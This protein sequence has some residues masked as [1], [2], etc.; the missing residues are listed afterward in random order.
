MPFGGYWGKILRVNLTTKKISVQEFDE[1]FARKWLGGVGFAVKICYDE[2]PA[3]ADPLGPENLLVYACGPY[4]GYTAIQGSGRFAVCGK[5]PLTGIWGQSTGGGHSAEELKRAGFDAVVV[6]GASDKPVYIYVNDGEIEIKD[7]NHLWGKDAGET[8]D[9]LKQELGDKVRVVPIGPAGENL[10]RYAGVITEKGHGC[11]GRMGMG[12]IMGSKKLKALVFRGTM[13]QPI[14]NP[15]ELKKLNKEL[16]PVLQNNDF[17]KQNRSDGQAMAV[18]PREENSLL[19]MGNFKVGSWK[20][21]ARKIGAAGGEFNEVLKPQPD[22]CSYCI[23]GC[24]R[25]VIID[26]GGPYDMDGYGPEYETLG[27]MGSDCLVDNLKAINYA[28]HL[29]NLYSLDTIE[30]GGVCAFAMDAYENGIIKKEDL[31]FELP[32][33]DGDAMIKL[34]NLIAFRKNK[35]GRLLGEGVKV[36]SEKLGCPQLAVQ[37]NNSVIPAHDPRAFFSMAVTYATGSRGACHVTGFSEAAELGVPL[38]EYNLTDVPLDRF[39]DKQ[40]GLAAL[41]WMDFSMFDDA[42]IICLFYDFSGYT[43]QTKVDFLKAVT[44]WE[45]YTTTEALVELGGRINQI[46]RMFNLKQGLIPEKDEVLPSRMFEPLKEGGAAG[47]DLKPVFEKM[48]A[49]Y[50]SERGWNVKGIPTP[51]TLKRFGLDFAVVDIDKVPANKA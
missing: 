10:V 8:E 36:A 30:F 46:C 17:A 11:A 33:G 37:V 14:A 12:A 41:A 35:L 15:E 48:R 1:A 45:D 19:P 7:A 27:M 16:L 51:E 50:Y 49:E 43:T 22:S 9:L 38:P 20:E 5:S 26:E 6:S 31:G 24:H 32:F 4:Q 21:G 47:A 40:K 13:R 18:I 39:S 3:E 23:V 28:A 34:V 29:C 42:L 25:R 2:I 44:G